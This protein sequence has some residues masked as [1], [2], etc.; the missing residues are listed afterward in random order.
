[1]STYL[2]IYLPMYA[3]ALLFN[4]HTLRIIVKLFRAGAHIFTCADI[5]VCI[6][7]NLDHIF[8]RRCTHI[9]II[10]L[11]S[12]C[13]VRYKINCLYTYALAHRLLHIHMH[14]FTCTH[15]HNK[16]RLFVCI[17]ICIRIHITFTFT[18]SKS[19]CD[20][21]DIKTLYSHM[22]MNTYSYEQKG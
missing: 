8:F 5:H 13:I 12:F 7:I 21:Q 18:F 17:C 15:I 9:Q 19:E 3:P 10:L 6:K 11:L 22:H 4:I 1:M 20:P 16:K 14:V 2:C